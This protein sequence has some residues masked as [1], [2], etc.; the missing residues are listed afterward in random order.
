MTTRAK[1]RGETSPA[2]DEF[3]QQLYRG[4]E[5]LAAGKVIEAKE[6]A[7]RPKDREALPH[8]RQ[9]LAERRQG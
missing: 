2:D 6:F 4:G 1:G 8:Y 3:L 7:N 5:L 9:V